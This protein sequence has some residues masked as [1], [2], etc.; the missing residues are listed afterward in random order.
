MTNTTVRPL[1]L[2]PRT[3]SSKTDEFCGVNSSAPLT[4]KDN[5]ATA[6]PQEGR[7]APKRCD[8]GATA[9]P[10]A[11]ARRVAVCAPDSAGM[12]ARI[13]GRVRV[14]VAGCWL[15]TGAKNSRGYGQIAAPSARSVHRVVVELDGRVIGDGLYVCHTCDVKACVNPAHLYVGSPLDN[16]TDAKERGLLVNR[17]AT[18][19]AAKTHCPQGHPYTEENLRVR[20]VRGRAERRCVACARESDRRYRL[21]T[22][23]VAA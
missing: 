1:G 11:W 18:E 14:D 2:E 5:P 9:G 4:R 23:A 22:K 6:A 20:V 8:E 7:T 21:R 12:A 15:W 13:A 10:R 3:Y 19:N 16:A 17:L